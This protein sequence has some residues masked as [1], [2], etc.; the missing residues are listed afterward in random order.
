MI[1]QRPSQEDILNV[2]TDR[3]E[4]CYDKHVE[5]SELY[6]AVV[7]KDAIEYCQD[8]E[9]IL[10]AK[11]LFSQSAMTQLLNRK[12]VPVLFYNRC[13][14]NL[15][16]DIFNHFV[17]QS[18]STHL[19]RMIDNGPVLAPPE[20]IVEQNVR[21]CLTD[22]YGIVDDHQVFP[23]VFEVLADQKNWS[24]REFVQD[25]QV[26]RMLI[27]FN[28]ATAHFKDIDHTAGLWITNSETGHSAVWIEPVVSIPGCVFANRQVLRNQNVDIRIVHRGEVDHNRVR[29]MVAAAKDV[30]QVGLVQVMEAWED[31]IA[32]AH[33]LR[34]AKSIDSFPKR[35]YDILEEEWADEIELAKAAVAQRI[36]SL[37]AEMPL[38]QR[39]QVEQS[40][41]KVI[42][43]FNNYKVR[44]AAIVEE[45]NE[46]S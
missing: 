38:F 46:D 40:A 28:D 4:H 11:Y 33:A 20:E 41:S 35:M 18:K 12:N 42:G 34:F 45:I 5:A 14:T 16:K 8:F 23:V 22:H 21:A 13:P 6:A 15:K 30:A 26:T 7:G 29:S 25:E 3:K 39:I 10:Q 37:A 44:M 36:M 17:G 9:G 31:K 27:H 24:I 1:L 43:L 19:F 2:I 32:S